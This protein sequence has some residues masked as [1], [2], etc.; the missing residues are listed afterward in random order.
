MIPCC[1]S[2]TG[3]SKEPAGEAGEGEHE[4]Y[5][6][7]AR[8]HQAS[9][10]NG[11]LE[12]RDGRR[13]TWPVAYAGIIPDA[14]Q[15]RLLERWYSPESSRGTLAVQGSSF[16]VAESRGQVIGFAP[17]VRRSAESAE[18]TRIYVWR[19]V[20]GA[21]SDDS[22]LRQRSQHSRQKA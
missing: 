16:F 8:G 3:A 20:S 2:D 9:G 15:Q 21:A 10:G 7:G 6:D 18:L 4:R 14:V 5:E 13:T 12:G 1:R 11:S 19:I 22:C 17:F